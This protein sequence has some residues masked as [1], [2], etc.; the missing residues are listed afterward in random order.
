MKL[1]STYIGG[2]QIG[3]HNKIP[4]YLR[5]NFVLGSIRNPWDWY[6]SLWGY[7]C[8]NKGSVYLQSTRQTSFRYCWR[9]LHREMG[10]AHVQPGYLLKQMRHDAKKNVGDWQSV[11][12]DANDVE[13]FRRWVQLMFD[14]DRALDIGEGY[15]FSPFSQSAGVLSYRFFKLFTGL[16]EKLYD[17]A[18]NTNPEALKEI[19][20][21]QGFVDAFVRQERLEED[22]L[23]AL[24]KAGISVS[25]SDREAIMA[26][27]NKKTNTSSRKDVSHYYDEQ[28]ANIIGT[29][30]QFIVDRFGYDI[31]AVLR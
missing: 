13:G 22:F 30:E 24:K 20:N 19:W 26:G 29:R 31:N 23:A 25:E 14:A 17:E 10:S 9:Q 28:T 21:T 6:V 15:G 4:K 5:K 8:D 18:L 2:E 1:L 12:T 11:Y 7:G 3:K 27:K 16:D